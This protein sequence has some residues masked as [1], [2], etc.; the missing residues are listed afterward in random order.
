ME[1]KAERERLGYLSALG[2]SKSSRAVTLF[3]LLLVTDSKK[4]SLH[5]CR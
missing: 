3:P 1:Q 4:K 2:D 5:D